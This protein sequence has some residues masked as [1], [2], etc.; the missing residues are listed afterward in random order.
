MA[1]CALSYVKFVSRSAEP[2]VSV[3]EA[4]YERN[5]FF[6]NESPLYLKFSVL[7]HYVQV[8]Y[9]LVHPPFP[10]ILN[11]FCGHSF[12]HV[13]KT[14]KNNHDPI[15]LQGHPSPHSGIILPQ[16]LPNSNSSA[17]SFSLLG[18]CLSR[19]IERE[20]RRLGC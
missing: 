11:I 4:P 17:G 15:N 18:M 20:K 1:C 2:T 12:L 7:A 8:V 10:F 6:Q 5:I 14:V 19:N 9:L 3:S 13:F 16:V